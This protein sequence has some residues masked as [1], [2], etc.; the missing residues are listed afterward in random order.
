VARILA[1][2]AAAA[3]TR[4]FGIRGVFYRFAGWAVDLTST[5]IRSNCG[6]V[7]WP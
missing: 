4:P 1:G 2:A 7:A 3:V 5:S 6:T